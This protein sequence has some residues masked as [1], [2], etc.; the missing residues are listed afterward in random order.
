MNFRQGEAFP[1]GNL[2]YCS[3]NSSNERLETMIAISDVQQAVQLVGPDEIK[4]NNSKQV[5]LPGP[6]QILC[7]VEA[8]GLCFS[9]LKLLKQFS[10]HGRKDMI[11]S[12]IDQNILR[13]L[14]SYVPNEQ[15]TVPGH[16][17]VV[18]IVAVG[19]GVTEY[20]TGEKYLVQAD[21]RW[22]KTETSNA[23]FGY[24]FEGGLQQY[25]LMDVRVIT[26]PEGESTLLPVPEGLSNSSVALVEPWACVEDA[27]MSK[28]RLTIKQGGRMLIVADT[29]PDTLLLNNMLSQYGRPAEI[30]WLS[31]CPAGDF[32]VPITEIASIE[33]LPQNGFDDII[34]LGTD[35][36]TAEAL[37]S[38]LDIKG[39]I[40]FVQA[41]REFDREIS[42]PVGRIHYG[43]IRITGTVSADPA[44]GMK[45]IPETGEVRSG[46]TMN[47][48]GAGGPMGM[49]HVIRNVSLDSSNLAVL[50]CDMDD[51]RLAALS[52]VAG[53]M[54]ERNGVVYKACNPGREKPEMLFSYIA[55][56]VPSAKMAAAAVKQAGNDA[57]IN[58]FAGI[59]ATE[60]IPIDLNRYI[61]QRIYFIGTSGSTVDDMKSVLEK[62]IAGRLA[63][64]VSVAAV[65]DLASAE[66]GMRAVE[67]RSIAGKILVYPECKD[68][69]LVELKDMPK[70]LPQVAA[71]LNDGVWNREA[72]LKLI[73]LFG[74]RA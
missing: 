19:A 28:E 25:V 40:N 39:L 49:M 7:R 43:G 67:N 5:H 1:I 35:A 24:N 64:D 15:P 44:E 63:T 50:A 66:Q 57:L 22:L 47:V 12:G 30:S 26:S 48:I 23:A 3:N 52:K 34:Y 36:N 55:L 60:Y 68:L 8:V 51:E 72:E 31:V 61:K 18:M 32:G 71:L 10:N 27:Y 11:V 56:M 9:D 20:K 65:S 33:A 69:G 2:S 46:D 14:P 53:P 6:Y 62:V 38:K 37:F 13:N 41:G 59:P 16:E 54:A 70:K 17:A 29:E 73:E 58:L 45:R 42:I 74:S 21:Y 4:T